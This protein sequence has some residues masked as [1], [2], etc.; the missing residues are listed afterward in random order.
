[1]YE[2]TGYIFSLKK[3]YKKK[4]TVFHIEVQTVKKGIIFI[5]TFT[6]WAQ[7]QSAIFRYAV[8]KEMSNKLNASKIVGEDYNTDSLDSKV[9]T[10]YLILWCFVTE[11][12]RENWIVYLLVWN[13]QLHELYF[14]RTCFWC[15]IKMLWTQWNECHWQLLTVFNTHFTL[16]LIKSV[17][18][19]GV[20]EPY[21]LPMLLVL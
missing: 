5:S 3:K 7:C 10:I 17:L 6:F 16:E 1:M 20:I 13:G 14:F 19:H 15:I 11:I 8:G 12:Y 9:C 21:F 4:C 2:F 18:M